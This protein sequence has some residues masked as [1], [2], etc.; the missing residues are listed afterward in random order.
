MNL[1]LVSWDEI[2]VYQ[3]P[4]M[5]GKKSTFHDMQWQHLFLINIW[6]PK[7]C[8]LST[9][10][11]SRILTN[12]SL[13]SFKTNT[14]GATIYQRAQYENELK[15]WKIIAV[16]IKKDLIMKYFRNYKRLDTPH[17]GNHFMYISALFGT[18]LISMFL[19]LC[20]SCIQLL[21][22]DIARYHSSFVRSYHTVFQVSQKVQ[23]NVGSGD[24]LFIL[25]K[26]FQQIRR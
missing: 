19:R 26:L 20:Y 17:A 9:W 1:K 21:I 2:V 18:N 10:S 8:F 11:H 5:D 24:P 23:S 16:Q 12:T 4:S 25:V 6:L 15:C 3:A 13:M 7:T 22:L 14:G